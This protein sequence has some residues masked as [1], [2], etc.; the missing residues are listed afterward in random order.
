VEKIFA[1]SLDQTG[2]LIPSVYVHLPT[3]LCAFL[4]PIIT[5]L[6]LLMHYLTK[7]LH[8]INYIIVS[9]LYSQAIIDNNF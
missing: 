9:D 7:M 4:S 3:N 2:D 8:S 6:Y 1:P 5:R